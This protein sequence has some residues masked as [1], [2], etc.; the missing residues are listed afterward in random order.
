M[1]RI[2]SFSKSVLNSLR[3]GVVKTLYLYGKELY[4]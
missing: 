1:T 4:E 3:L 2:F